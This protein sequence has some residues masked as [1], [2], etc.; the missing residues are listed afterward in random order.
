M[1]SCNLDMTVLSSPGFGQCEQ[2]KYAVILIYWPFIDLYHISSNIFRLKL[3]SLFSHF[4][5]R[6]NS[7]F[8]CL[9]W[10]VS[11]SIA[12]FF[13]IRDA[14]IIQ[15]VAKSDTRIM[16]ACVLF[17]LLLL[18]VSRILFVFLNTGIIKLVFQEMVFYTP[19]YHSWEVMVSS[20]PII[21]YVKLGL[22]FSHVHR[23]V[24]FTLNFICH[25]FALQSYSLLLIPH[26]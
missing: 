15:G 18:I 22:F 10:T 17:C 13:R 20:E 11:K 24:L 9:L 19:R 23:L 12:Y 3:L 1:P 21:F 16:V 8:C 26:S 2:R 14:C 6:N 4:F 7:V 5:Y 25:F